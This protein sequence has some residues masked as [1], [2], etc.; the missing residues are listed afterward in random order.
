MNMARGRTKGWTGDLSRFGLY[1]K[2]HGIDRAKIA[3]GAGVTP[4]YI[5]MLAHGKAQPGFRRAVAIERWTRLNVKAAEQPAPFSCG[6]WLIEPA[7]AAEPEAPSEPP[8]AA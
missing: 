8:A 7:P 3:A 4:S 6:D 5:S 1:L 2:R